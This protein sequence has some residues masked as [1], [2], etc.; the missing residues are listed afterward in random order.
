ME[1]PP[2]YPSP[3]EAPL[4]PPGAGEA[5]ADS[6][7]GAD[8]AE[9]VLA[10]VHARSKSFATA[11]LIALLCTAVAF[12]GG[13][14]LAADSATCARYAA[15]LGANYE[16]CAARTQTLLCLPTGCAVVLKKTGHGDARRTV[17]ET[18]YTYACDAGENTTS[19]AWSRMD[20]FESSQDAYDAKAICDKDSVAEAPPTLKTVDVPSRMVRKRGFNC[21]DA[22]KNHSGTPCSWMFFTGFLLVGFFGACAVVVAALMLV[23]HPWQ[24]IDYTP[25][26]PERRRG[27]RAPSAEK[28]D[29]PQGFLA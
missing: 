27:V 10:A 7:R 20:V 12:S 6:G 5:P 17:F 1:S 16:K 24:A 15:R 3:E 22:A 18:R 29:D 19:E 28:T 8:E 4:V 21:N 14:I 13:V 25:V 26:D 2:A 9:A 11:S 23:F